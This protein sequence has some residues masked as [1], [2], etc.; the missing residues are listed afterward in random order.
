[1][2]SRLKSSR[3]ARD[4]IKA[5]E[6]F[7]GQAVQRARGWMVGY[8]HTAAAREG[9]SISPEDAELLLLHDVLQAERAVTASVGEGLPGEVFDALVSVA[10]SMGPAAFRVCDVARLARE[11]RHREAANAIE[12]WVRAQE[13]G[14]LVVSERLARRRAAEKALYLSALAEDSPV[15]SSA[16][17][18]V[19]EPAPE[20]V[21]EPAAAPEIAPEAGM[22]PAL[23]DSEPVELDIRFE[24][25]APVDMTAEQ[26]VGAIEDGP[27]EEPEPAREPQV[28]AEPESEPEAAPGSEP[29]AAEV[30]EVEPTDTARAR[31]DAVMQTVLSRMAGQMAR[32]GAAIDPEPVETVADESGPAASP[33]PHIA[34]S[35][36]GY[37]FLKPWSGAL[38]PEPEPETETVARAEPNPETGDPGAQEPAMQASAAPGPVYGSA[39][40]SPIK[41]RS[42]PPPPSD[43]EEA[44]RRAATTGVSGEV[45][46]VGMP[47]DDDAAVE[48]AHAETRDNADEDELHPSVVAG[49]EAA[50]IAL[51]EPEAEPTRESRG[52]WVFLANLLVG[53]GLL[54]AGGWDLVSHFETYRAEGFFFFGPIAFAAGLVLTLA[55]AW[56]V[57]ARLS[58]RARNAKARKRANA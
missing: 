34:Q 2:T 41:D 16:D 23:T 31:Q 20:P 45:S 54:G 47:D 7:H 1:M 55:S 10:A 9:V 42:D 24:E 51:S 44:E 22:E 11:G 58:D 18:D 12:T 39:V 33:A 57:I 32:A 40:A 19:P 37:S 15:A 4:L 36:L 25:P 8:G 50:D 3:A 38:E 29:M 49:P 30:S 43:V 21:P 56:F 52:D 46:G 53:L 14:R 6:P 48:G 35:V 13:D 17:Q 27:A 26:D 28:Q 5:H